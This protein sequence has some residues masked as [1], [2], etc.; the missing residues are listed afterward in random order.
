MSYSTEYADRL[1]RLTLLAQ[2]GYS[3]QALGRPASKTALA[4]LILQKA[5]SDFS[6]SEPTSAPAPKNKN[7][8]KKGKSVA[9]GVLDILSRPSYAVASAADEAFNDP[10]A[11]IGSTLKA[12]G[13]GLSGKNDVSFIDVLQHQHINEI[14]DRPEYKRILENYGQKEADYYAQTEKDL[15]DKGRVQDIVPGVIN[16]FTFDPLNLVGAGILKKPFDAIRD[17]SKAASG[18]SDVEALGEAASLAGRQAASSGL[19]GASV[20]APTENLRAAGEK[21]FG[22]TNG[23]KWF[24]NQGL[25][26][27]P[28]RVFTQEPGPNSGIPE[29]FVKTPP[30]P[31]TLSPGKLADVNFA[32]TMPSNVEMPKANRPPFTLPGRPATQDINGIPVE[33]LKGKK[34]QDLMSTVNTEPKFATLDHVFNKDITPDAYAG[35]TKARVV[36]ESAQIVDQAAKGNPNTLDFLAPKKAG[37]LT[38][39]AQKFV[40]DTV[41]HVSNEIKNSIADPVKARAAGKQ[42]RHPVYNAPSQNNLSNKLTTAARQQFEAE[43]FN[44]KTGNKVAKG[45]S[46]RFVPAV[47]ERYLTML[48]NAEETMVAKGRDLGDDA[49][50]PRGG[51]KPNTPYLR[52]SDVLDRLPKEIAQ[53]AILG[54]RTADK[55][56]PSVLLRAVTGDKKA[57]GTIARDHKEL[58][59]AI[60]QVDWAPMMTKEYALRVID[61]TNKLQPALDTSANLIHQA[62]ALPNSDAERA[63]VA[64][65]VQKEAKAQFKNEM[66]S[67]KGTFSDLLRKMAKPNEN[68]V[69]Q[70]INARKAK[71]AAG[72]TNGVN[73][74]KVAQGPRIAVASAH[75]EEVIGAPA[76]A[77]ATNPVLADQAAENGIFST[78]LSWIKPDYGY[79][80]LRPTV[81]KNV[82]VRKSSAAVRASQFTK[83]LDM[84]P[85]GEHLTFWK[86]AQGAI[87]VIPA[88]AEAVQQLQRAIGNMFGE[89]GLADKFA[90]NSSVARA[91]ISIH[92]LNKHL[93]IAGVKDFQFTKEAKD[94][95][96]GNMVKFDGHTMLQTWKNYVPKGENDLRQ[97]I[98]GLTQATE[99]VMVEYSAFANMGAIWG[100][101]T[102]RDGFIKVS[103]MHPAIDGLH[104]PKDIVD[105]IGKFS[106]GIDEFYE[107]LSNNKL[108]SLYDKGLRTWKSGVTIY[109]PS[110][111]IR[112]MMGDMF[113]AWLDGVDNPVYYTKAARVLKANHG[114]YSDIDPS[115]NSLSKILGEGRETQIL[116][117]ILGQGNKRIPNGSGVISKVRV[118]GKRYQLTIDQVYQMGFRHGLFPHSNVI[119]DMPGSETLMESL[120]AKFHPGKAGP[121]QPLGG[122]GQKMA[123]E[124]SES[125][126]H[127]ARI[128][129][130]LYALENTHANSLADLFEKSAQRVRKYHPDG[131]DLTTTEKRVLR[132][133]FP[134]YAWTRK[135][136]PLI[137]EGIATHPAKIMA[138]PKLMSAAQELNGQDSSVSDPWPE[139][140]L[141]PDWLAG[142]PIGPIFDPTS[143]LSKAIARSD[144]EVGYT[145]VN[146][147]NPATDLLQQFG[148]NPIQGVGN[149]I[150]PFLKIPAEI[151]FGQE[152]MSGAPITDKTTYADKNIPM[153]AIL[154]RMTN[155]AVGTGILEGGDLKKNETS[156]ANIAALMNYLTGAGIL[157]T[158]RYTKG[159]EFDLRKRIAAQN[160]KGG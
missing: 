122:R 128:A 1:K 103:G 146:P 72:V 118:G 74:Q 3:S 45:A 110:H 47:Y 154:S 107:P 114:H 160:Q 152:F 55:V 48:R 85:V 13:Q 42:P 5:R 58:S 27:D 8:L 123:R 81:I 57:L 138:Y 25:F 120:A 159:G 117:E 56:L 78:V 143:Q 36:N 38:P 133:L 127:Y 16:D 80:E 59:D 134:F 65:A 41:D 98:F 132:R 29:A 24:E 156:P 19:S 87:E 11:G 37:S 92:D 142:N 21:V 15:I 126:E 99:N 44:P 139:D 155:G 94:P 10:N 149:S 153:L 131:L 64:D 111:H 136:I 88:H 119:E 63:A 32:S 102:A 84:V 61:A 116:G 106:R 6:V 148:N 40:T 90:G 68:V 35:L 135:A 115:K 89:S 104:F 14:K 137:V 147:G 113:L 157:D 34:L 105:Q 75:I 62:K 83:I 108:L 31:D 101:K 129:H 9:L 30:P 125:R 50:Y 22:K 66:P 93:R 54:P 144:S 17:V 124:V 28:N 112:N 69:E 70:I 82:S 60:R 151:G 77:A 79:K 39:V 97:F 71:L 23:E 43:S 2:L 150:T 158:G 73:G 26:K 67:V 52:L 4:N 121:F 49:F 18:L 53:R 76:K 96:T 12:A 140:Q 141:F 95:L 7:L 145:L 91:G 130:Y 51:I 33:A 109:S 100:S 46:N 20:G 86:E